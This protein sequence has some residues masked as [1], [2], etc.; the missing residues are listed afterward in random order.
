MAMEPEWKRIRMVRGT[1]IAAVA[2]LW[3]VPLFIFVSAFSGNWVA[4]WRAVGVPSMTPHFLD[5][6]G[7]PTAIET[8]HSGGDPMI[9]N[10]ADPLHRRM[11]YPRIWLYLF[12]AARITRRNV[13][14]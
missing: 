11:N 6:Y 2:A 9:S 4:T 8:L 5:L 3:L 1:K 10:Q 12:S 14:I 13:S 7:I